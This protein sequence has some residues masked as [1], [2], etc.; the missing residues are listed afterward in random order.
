ML[1]PV[2]SVLVPPAAAERLKQG[3]GIGEAARLGL[4]KVD[5]GLL[6]G[7]FGIQSSVLA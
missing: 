1:S 6:V 4:H 7:L 5:A 3:R 2:K